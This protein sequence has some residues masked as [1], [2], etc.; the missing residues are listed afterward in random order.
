LDDSFINLDVIEL[1]CPVSLALQLTADLPG[2]AGAGGKSTDSGLAVAE[3]T[4]I[5]GS[6][7]T[8]KNNSAN[9]RYR[10]G[11][12]K[13]TT[14]DGPRKQQYFKRLPYRHVGNKH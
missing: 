3:Y 12:R 13:G 10:S 14:T 8:V 11:H 5:S 7:I 4:R 2:R 9:V 1:F 6:S